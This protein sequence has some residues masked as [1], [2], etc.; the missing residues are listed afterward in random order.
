MFTVV[1]FCMMVIL[2]CLFKNE[3]KEIFETAIVAS[4]LLIGGI[5]GSYVF[6]ATW[7]DI[8]LNKK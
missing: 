1:G 2:Y 5:V 3:D 8:K 7:Q 6:G 4:Y